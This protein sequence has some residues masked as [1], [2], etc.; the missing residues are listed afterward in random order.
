MDAL[1]VTL[2]MVR[3]AEPFIA[4]FTFVGLDSGVNGQVA[5]K[6]DVLRKGNS[7]SRAD[8]R[9]FSAMST[10]MRLKN[11]RTGESF[12]TGVTGVCFVIGMFLHVCV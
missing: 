6:V 9:L 5:F 7:T 4:D 1:N 12:V 3:A 10:K 2:Q 8:E 11:R